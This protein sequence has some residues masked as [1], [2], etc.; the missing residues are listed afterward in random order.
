[1]LFYLRLSGVRHMVKGHSD[2]ER[3][4]LLP[5][6]HGLLFPISSNGSFVCTNPDRTAHTSLCY[7]SRGALAGMRNSLM[8]PP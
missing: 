3:R 2:S 6:L 8:G 4:N 1:M 7:T 5:P